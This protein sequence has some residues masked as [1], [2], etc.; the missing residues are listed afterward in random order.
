MICM[1]KIA[2]V[3]GVM[4]G[5]GY[6]VSVQTMFDRPLNNLGTDFAQRMTNLKLMGCDIIR[7][8]FPDISEKDYLINAVK[9]CPMPVVAD[10]HFNYR[11]ALTAMDCG[12][13]AVRINPGNIGPKWK[14]EE[15]IKKASDKNCAI[16]IGLNSGSL[17]LGEGDS[18]DIMVDSA[19]KYISWF[20]NKNFSNTV[21]SLKSSDPIQT[22][23][24]NRMFR[25]KSSYPLHLGVTEAGTLISSC[26]KS[27][28]V[29][30]NLLSEKIGD[31]IRYSISGSIE[32][33]VESGSQLLQML[34]LRKKR[35]R[36]VSC[37]TCGRKSFDTVEFLDRIGPDLSLIDKQLTI[38]VMG[39]VVNGPGEAKNADLAVC[40]IG[41]DIYIY[42][43]G[44]ILEKTDLSTVKDRLLKLIEEI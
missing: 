1:D 17:P 18:V 28:W 3:G 26:I 22:I 37:P 41:H 36:V 15:I 35:I 27:T 12:V 8:S 11:N 25:K 44:V 2:N 24:A 16:R 19:L 23:R 34:G 30:G 32:S 6:P 39:C 40:G 42:K 7:F 14:T 5:A 43:S 31:T 10:I 21:V 9:L 38:A 29:F 4:I 20:E 33:E 13:D